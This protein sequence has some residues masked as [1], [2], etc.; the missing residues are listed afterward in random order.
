[1]GSAALSSG[2]WSRDMRGDGKTWGIK[3]F[4]NTPFYLVAFSR[5]VYDQK[6]AIVD[7]HELELF[8]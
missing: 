5:R 2:K 4:E 7:H 3:D 6:E 8:I 1:M